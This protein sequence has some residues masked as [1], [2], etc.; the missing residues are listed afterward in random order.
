V[1][2]HLGDNAEPE[3]RERTDRQP[4]ALLDEPSDQRVVVEAAVAVIEPLDPQD[5][6]CL[7]DILRATSS[8]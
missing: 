1:L 8:G 4:D 7:P 3:V 2:G 6:K 5:V